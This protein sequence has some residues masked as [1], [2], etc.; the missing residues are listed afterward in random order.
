MGRFH[1]GGSAPNFFAATVA[2]AVAAA[3]DAAA[4][5]IQQS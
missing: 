2:V 4:F 1:L 5:A 3:S